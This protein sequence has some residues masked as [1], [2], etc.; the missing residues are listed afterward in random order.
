MEDVLGS[1]GAGGHIIIIAKQEI[2]TESLQKVTSF[3]IKKKRQFF[4]AKIDLLY[5]NFML[6]I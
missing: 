5:S 2:S 4:F 3:Y 6:N 1:S